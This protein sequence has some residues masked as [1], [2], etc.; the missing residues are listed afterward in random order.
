MVSRFQYDTRAFNFRDVLRPLF[1][2]DGI[3]LLAEH[4]G[5]DPA[6]VGLH[7]SHVS[8]LRS[9]MINAFH[10]NAFLNVYR[11]FAR[12]LL[13]K[14]FD[15]PIRVQVSP[16]PRIV[17]AGSLATSWH[18]DNWYGH[19]DKATTFWLPLTTMQPGSGVSFIRDDG[20]LLD[21]IETG[22]KTGDISLSDIN[23]LCASQGEEMLAGTN[24]YLGFGA[25][26]L[27]GSP[28]NTSGTHRISF[29]FRVVPASAP[30]GSKHPGDYMLIDGH[31]HE[32]AGSVP[33]QADGV[34]VK[35]IRGSPYATAKSQ[36]M[37]LEIFAQQSALLIGRNEAEIEI[38]GF[39]PVLAA[40]AERRVPMPGSFGTV[41]LFSIHLLPT[42]PSVLEKI[43][44]SAVEN[45]VKLHFVAEDLVFPDTIDIPG[46]MAR[47]S[48][49]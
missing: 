7:E 34:A 42:T 29:D 38:E 22:L 43:L 40:Y 13:D 4:S 47:A 31:E 9:R 35:Y 1:T 12:H 41:L 3:D 25:R 20:N 17:I 24:E 46:C 39:A 14:H 23:T 21:R 27:H 37:M 36:H 18:T 11:N 6:M 33:A 45:R 16:T 5:S 19:V 44:R 26:V 10:D 15:G 28:Q 49:R 48:A 30:L 2:I 32:A 8:I